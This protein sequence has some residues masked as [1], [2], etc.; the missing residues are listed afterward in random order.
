L[1][2]TVVVL[3]VQRLGCISTGHQASFDC[4][5][6]FSS[7]YT[8]TGSAGPPLSTYTIDAADTT[9]ST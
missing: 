3:S 1:L 5:K 8:H 2:L 9:A 6:V 7:R 4:S